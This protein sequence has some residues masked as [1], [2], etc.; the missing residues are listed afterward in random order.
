MTLMDETFSDEKI[1][2]KSSTS[3]LR[4]D[5]PLKRSILLPKNALLHSY[6]TFLKTYM[7]YV[8]RFSP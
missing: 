1:E 3:L 4:L 7:Q 6:V 2:S 5:L 8:S